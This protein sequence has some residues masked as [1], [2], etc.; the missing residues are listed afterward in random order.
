[1]NETSSAGTQTKEKPKRW[2]LRWSMRAFFIA[3][4]LLCLVFGLVGQRLY[5]GLVHADVGEQLTLQAE[6]TPIR[7]GFPSPDKVI[8]GWTIPHQ[9]VGRIHFTNDNTLPTWMKWTNSDILF[10]RL[11]RVAILVGI[12]ND[13]LEITF[14]QVHRLERIRRMT[15]Q[16]FLTAEQAQRYLSRLK[17][18][19]LYLRIE[20]GENKPLPFLRDLGVEVLEIHNFPEAAVDDLPLSLKQLDIGGADI[21]DRSLSKFV[22]LKTLETLDLRHVH[23]AASEKGIEELRRQMPWC[24]ILWKPRPS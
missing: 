15:I 8:I 20:R 18:R 13:E 16:S 1:M 19:D 7:Y 6:K 10:R 12:P 11:D 17:I 14:Q 3:I 21:S 9:P 22:R 24:E 4:T 2:R 5:V 23:P